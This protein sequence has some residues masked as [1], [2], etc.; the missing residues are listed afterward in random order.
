MSD[1]T[2]GSPITITREELHKRAWETP[3][4]ELRE[5]GI[6]RRSGRI[7]KQGNGKKF[8]AAT[9]RTDRNRWAAFIEYAHRLVVV[10][11]VEKFIAHL[12][13]RTSDFST[14]IDGQPISDGLQR[15]KDHLEKF[16]PRELGRKWY[17]LR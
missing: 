8:E 1:P 17:S 16:D 11:Q 5:F 9:Q 14:I 2:N 15:A 10:D 4:H 3:P 6:T 13:R 7:S 12:E